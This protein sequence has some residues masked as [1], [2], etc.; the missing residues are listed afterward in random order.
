LALRISGFAVAVGAGYF[1]IMVVVGDWVLVH[2]FGRSFAPY[3]VLIWPMAVTQ[4]L[5]AC[6][7]PFSVLLIAERR[8]RVL[9]V[10]GVV[11]CVATFGFAA[12]LGAATG[13]TGA[14]WGFTAAAAA[15]AVYLVAAARVRSWNW[16]KPG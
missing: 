7:F 11:W 3:D 14:A 16:E 9:L 13:V 8:G 10:S 1:L 12:A 6:S 15:S 4:L 2:L 5:S